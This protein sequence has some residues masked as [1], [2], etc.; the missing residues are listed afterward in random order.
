MNIAR[1][2]LS[3]GRASAA[4][5]GRPII[6]LLADPQEL[7]IIVP[8]L[9]TSIAVLTADSPRGPHRQAGSVTAM[10]IVDAG[11]EKGEG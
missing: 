2:Y 5:N 8:S 4:A 1:G 6:R 11:I 7:F 3:L 9:A 10:D